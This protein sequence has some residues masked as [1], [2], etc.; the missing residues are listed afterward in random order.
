MKETINVVLFS[1]GRGTATIADALLR[2]PQFSLTLLVNAYDDG[3]STG[4]LRS[5]IPGMLGPSDIRKNICR[6]ISTDNQSN[7]ALKFL[8]EYRFPQN[9]TYH[10]GMSALTDILA[11]RD[12]EGFSD[13]AVVF[14]QLSLEKARKIAIGFASFIGFAQKRANEG[15]LFDFSDCSL[16]NILFSS[17]YLASANDFNLAIT[18]FTQLCGVETNILNINNGKNLFLAGIKADGTLLRS[19][20]E[21]VAPQNASGI[22]E[23]FLLSSPLSEEDVKKW[24][25]VPIETT[26]ADLKNRSVSPI[27]SPLAKMAIQNADLIVYGPGTQHSSLF[28]SYLTEGLAHC[29]AANTRAEKV[30]VGNILKDYEIQSDTANSIVDKFLYYMNEKGRN[31]YKFKDLATQFFFHFKNFAIKNDGDYVGFLAA[32]NTLGNSKI[33]LKDW[34]VWNGMHS[35]RHVVDELIGVVNAR[36]QTHVKPLPHMVSIVVPGLNESRTVERVL[37]ELALLDFRSLNLSKEIIFVDGGSSD[38]TANIASANKDVK[39]FRLNEGAGRGDALRLGI[40]KASGDMTV[41]FPCDGEYLAQDLIPIVHI[42]IKNEFQV[43][44]G[45]RTI[46]CVNVSGR[47]REIYRGNFVGY[48][49]S[50]YGGILIGTLGLFL[51][52]RFVSDP[53]TGIKAFDTQVL[54]SLRLRSHGVDLDTELIAKLL[55]SGVFIFELPVEYRPRKKVE[56]KKTTVFDGIKALFALIRYRIYSN[57]KIINYYS[58]L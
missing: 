56:G 41:F 5:F 17:F 45:S 48:W 39:V 18:K 54:K 21:I 14:K 3:L 2:Y 13:L 53:L 50:K 36:F 46:K 32:E 8:L 20:A 19:E 23:I 7:I 38:G 51:Y 30:F 33:V 42:L 47:I 1:G 4:I 9:T 44:L 35:G 12:P 31:D 57:A 11:L 6:L 43:V 28:P 15:V 10:Q 27:L 40:E 26:I 16:G 52:N 29:I 34:E 37:R 24:I 55:K 25:D 22:L 58:C 49:I